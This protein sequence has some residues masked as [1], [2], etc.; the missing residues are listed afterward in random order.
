MC[1][2]LTPEAGLITVPQ[3]INDSQLATSS[4]HTG[5]NNSRTAFEWIRTG[6]FGSGPSF[7]AGNCP[8]ATRLRTVRSLTRNSRATSETVNNCSALPIRSWNQKGKL[9]LHTPD[10]F[11]AQIRGAGA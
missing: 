9:R 8:D 10:S 4:G 3:R 1:R 11:A 5:R 6:A 2:L 7:H